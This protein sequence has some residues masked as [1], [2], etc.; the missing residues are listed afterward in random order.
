MVVMLAGIG[1]GSL[2]SLRAELKKLTRKGFGGLGTS[3]EC[4]KSFEEILISDSVFMHKVRYDSY[5]HTA[6]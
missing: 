1:V 3:E 5:T 6:W 4:A 2:G